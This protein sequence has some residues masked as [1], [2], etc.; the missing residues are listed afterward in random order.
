MENVSLDQPWTFTAAVMVVWVLL[1]TGIEV[2]LFNDDVMGAVIT[3]AVIGLA[4]AFF[5]IVLRRQIES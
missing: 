2:I 3:G 4:F 1:W 5:Y